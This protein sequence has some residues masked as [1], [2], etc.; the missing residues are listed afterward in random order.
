MIVCKH[1]VPEFNQSPVAYACDEAVIAMGLGSTD[2]LGWHHCCYALELWVDLWIDRLCWEM[3]SQTPVFSPENY[4]CNLLGS[5]TAVPG[6]PGQMC[7]IFKPCL[8]IILLAVIGLRV[9]L[10]HITLLTFS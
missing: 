8:R 10:M 3:M 4:P 9:F 6:L 1:H 5:C 7:W 2:S